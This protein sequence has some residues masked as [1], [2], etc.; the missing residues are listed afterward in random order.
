M[1]LVFPQTF[2]NLSGQIVPWLR[3]K[4]VGDPFH[5]LILHDDLDTP[6]GV[7]RFREKGRSGGQKGVESILSATGT[8]E[9][10]RIKVGIGRPPFI[11]ADVSQYVLSHFSKEELER[12]PALMDHGF[13]LIE[14]WVVAH[15]VEVEG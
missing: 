15:A 2:M 10:P 8:T 5:W 13:S 14:K 3:R 9:L 12:L 11:G 6:F 7:I 4:G 1:M